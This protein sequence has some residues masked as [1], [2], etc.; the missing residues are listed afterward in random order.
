MQPVSLYFAA[1]LLLHPIAD[2]LWWRTRGGEVR[3]QHTASLAQCSLIIH[4]DATDL[5]LIWSRGKPFYAIVH[6]TG[7]DFPMDSAMKVAL[8]FD[9]EWITGSTPDQ[10]AL[11]EGDNV[12]FLLPKPVDD[13]LVSSSN[14]TLI[15]DNDH[16]LTMT[17]PPR[18]KLTALIA[19]AK[20][21]RAALNLPD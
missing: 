21:C 15:I 4:D 10:L 1:A 11:G 6:H 18:S 16:G 20:R 9:R 14:A 7:W 19:G 5:S 17:L 2:T 13:V 3:E 12:V 8:A